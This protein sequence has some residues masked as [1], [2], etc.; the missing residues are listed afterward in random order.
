MKKNY[1]LERSYSVDTDIEILLND[2]NEIYAN[3]TRD[4]SGGL[5]KE[6]ESYTIDIDVNGEIILEEN[7]SED[8]W[9]TI[10]EVFKEHIATN[11]VKYARKCDKCGK[12]MNEGYCIGGG[13]EYYCNPECLHQVYTTQEWEEMYETEDNDNSDNY[14]T[15]WETEEDYQYVLFNNQLITL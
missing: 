1:T 10:M 11:G 5:W 14:W 2:N 7:Q 12:G 4:I 8:E 15:E 6:E 3:V 13:E 9:D